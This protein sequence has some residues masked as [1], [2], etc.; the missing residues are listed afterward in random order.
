MRLLGPTTQV[1]VKCVVLFFFGRPHSIG[2]LT[3]ASNIENGTKRESFFLRMS[4][5]DCRQRHS[6]YVYSCQRF[7]SGNTLEDVQWGHVF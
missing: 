4:S 2:I 6:H 5:R 3:V 1:L 7:S